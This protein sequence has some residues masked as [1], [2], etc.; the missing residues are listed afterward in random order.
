MNPA[1]P[2]THK[3]QEQDQDSRVLRN[4]ETVSG[5]YAAVAD[6][7]IA[8]AL[9]AMSE[10]I[11]WVVTDGLPYGGTYRGR[12]EV[13]TN[14]FARFD[15]EWD[16]LEVVPE[17]I[18]AVRDAVVALGRYRGRHRGTGILMTARFAHVWRFAEGTAPTA[19]ETIADTHTMVAAMR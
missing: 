18:L 12:A 2:L 10:R 1:Q 11:E 8:A 5:I 15:T 16:G 14:V 9:G 3:A 19:F 7:D 6:G 13:L 17:E 4:Q